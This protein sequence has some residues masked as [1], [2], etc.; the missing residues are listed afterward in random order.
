MGSTT[1]K[2]YYAE[3]LTDAWNR[4][5]RPNPQES[6]TSATSATPQVNAGE[7]VAED[8]SG[9]RH[10]FAESATPTLRSVV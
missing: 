8:P 3:D 6:A 9:T 5:C 1:P 2:G 10:M 4:Y 7:S